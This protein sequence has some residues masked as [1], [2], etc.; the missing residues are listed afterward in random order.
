AVPRARGELLGEGLHP[1]LE[2]GSAR[3]GRL[4]PLRRL[5]PLLAREAQREPVGDAPGPGG[6]R[7]LVGG[8]G[9]GEG[10]GAPPAPAR[11][12]DGNAQGRPVSEPGGGQVA[13]GGYPLQIGD[14]VVLPI[15]RLEQLFREVDDAFGERVAA[16]RVDAYV[17]AARHEHR[18][19]ER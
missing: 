9:P 14:D 3:G 8:R 11:G 1:R 13:L 2:L 10:G 19:G 15:V 18:K 17:A 16:A 6:G 12:E 7:R 5:A 4:R